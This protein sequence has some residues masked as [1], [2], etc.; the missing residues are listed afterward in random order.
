MKRLIFPKPK[1]SNDS[2]NLIILR[3]ELSVEYTKIDFGYQPNYELEIGG[4][5]KI[6]NGIILHNNNKKFKLIKAENI[7]VSMQINFKSIE[8]WLLFSL[9]F[10]P[11]PFECTKFD[12]TKTPKSNKSIFNFYSI[13][14]DDNKQFEIK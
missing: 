5:I 13:E 12:I 3:I 1:Y 4:K 6:T 9:Y 14:L 8:D 2:N 11:L 10:E 7:P